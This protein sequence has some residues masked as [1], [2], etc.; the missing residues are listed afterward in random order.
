[1]G[2]MLGLQRRIE[3]THEPLSGP[4]RPPIEQVSTELLN[5]KERPTKAEAKEK[6][7]ERSSE[8]DKKANQDLSASPTPGSTRR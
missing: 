7:Q 4:H 8:R 6:S 2:V 3:I 5:L 1:M